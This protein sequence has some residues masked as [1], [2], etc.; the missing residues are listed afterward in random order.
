[1]KVSLIAILSCS[2]LVA[3][4]QTHVNRVTTPGVDADNNNAFLKGYKHVNVPVIDFQSTDLICRSP[5]L[6]A[7]G[8]KPFKIAGGGTISLRWNTKLEP[9]LGE[10][11]IAGPCSYWMAKASS[12]GTGPNWSKINAYYNTVDGDK[13]DWCSNKLKRAGDNA[14]YEFQLPKLVKGIYYLR[15]EIIDLSEASPTNYDDYTMGPRSY[16]S[17]MM[18]EITGDGTETL[19]NLVDIMDTYKPYY[20]DKLLLGGSVKLKDFT[21]PGPAAQWN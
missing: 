21:Y 1:M 6:T 10:F 4:A 15:A 16:A 14:Y 2:A 12:K 11:E 9:G 18:V 7:S 19:K 8:V 20:K 3:H 5:D 17:C 13:P